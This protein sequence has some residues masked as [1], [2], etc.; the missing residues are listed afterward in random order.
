MNG[1][2][3]IYASLLIAAGARYFWLDPKVSK[4]SRKKKA[5]P[6]KAYAWPAFLSGPRLP[7]SI[8]T[9]QMNPKYPNN[10]GILIFGQHNISHPTPFIEN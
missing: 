5:S 9:V 2:Y 4:K 8:G 7:N 3:S 6:R 1:L 10:C